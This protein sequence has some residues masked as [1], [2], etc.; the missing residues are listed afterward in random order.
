MRDL[1]GAPGLYFKWPFVDAVVYIDKRILALAL[2]RQISIGHF[3]RRIPSSASAIHEEKQRSSAPLSGANRQYRIYSDNA[4]TAVR[5]VGVSELID[6]DGLW[7]AR[8]RRV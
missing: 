7:F 3:R 2:S 8:Q 6:N 4:V 5:C 1:I